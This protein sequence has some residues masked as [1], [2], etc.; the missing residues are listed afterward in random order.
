MIY[1]DRFTQEDINAFNTLR[2][3]L[4][5]SEEGIDYLIGYMKIL[6]NFNHKLLINPFRGS[7]TRY[8][9]YLALPATRLRKLYFTTSK[10]VRLS[11][12]EQISYYINILEPFR[13]NAEQVTES[14]LN[15]PRNCSLNTIVCNTQLFILPEYRSQIYLNKRN[16][17]DIL[18]ETVYAGKMD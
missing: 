14:V 2:T 15:L 8:A 13:D 5:W 7:H 3:K 10:L 11:S 4:H 12:H 6:S 17:I 18:E 9:G 1:T 16:L